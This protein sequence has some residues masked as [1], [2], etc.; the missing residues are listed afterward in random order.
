MKILC[1]ICLEDCS[2]NDSCMI[3][4]CEHI[5]HTKCIQQL[6]TTFNTY[7][8]DKSTLTV[9]ASCPLCRTPIEKYVKLNNEND[10]CYYY[11]LEEHTHLKN[12]KQKEDLYKLVKYALYLI[13][14]EG[15]NL[16]KDVI[17]L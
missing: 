17:H 4:W 7:K 2:I 1:T 6:I 14:N 10:M 5:F 11:N 9:H 13:Q 3:W 8:N 16:F 15:V 12:I